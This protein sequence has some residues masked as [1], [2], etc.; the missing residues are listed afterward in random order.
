VG[1][2]WILVVV[3]RLGADVGS[4]SSA[5][6]SG[7]FLSLEHGERQMLGLTVRGCLFLNTKV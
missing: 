6:S 4:V 5:A 2:R 3:L 7:L 1:Y